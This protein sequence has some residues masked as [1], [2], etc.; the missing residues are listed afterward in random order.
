MKSFVKKLRWLLFWTVATPALAQTGPP[1]APAPATKA[2]LEEERQKWNE[3]LTNRR[4]GYKINEQP[5]ALLAAT[6]KG[7]KP[8]TALDLGMG[9]GRNTIFLAQQGWQATG[10]DIADEAVALAQANAKKAGVKITGVVQSVDD[11]D[12]GRNRWDLIACIYFGP[13]DYA[14]KIRD[15]LRPGGLVVVEVASPEAAKLQKM[16]A[17]VVYSI[18]ELKTIFSGYKILRADVQEG[19]SD[20]KLVQLP[21]VYFVAQ[22]P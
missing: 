5:N 13:R 20:F 21:L 18:E 12:F 19:I 1:A 9:Q 10:V 11:F 14:Q 8:G 3:V 4:P 22:K 15:S 16:G 7:R 6:V 2:A 17:G